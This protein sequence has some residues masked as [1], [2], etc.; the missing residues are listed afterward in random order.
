MA[1]AFLTKA[2][3]Q[4]SGP[5]EVVGVGLSS[6]SRG[7]EANTILAMKKI[8]IDLGEYKS[9]KLTQDVIN[10]AVVVLCM[11]KEHLNSLKKLFNSVP[12]RCYLWR[13]FLGNSDEDVVDPFGCDLETYITVR[14]SISEAIPS[15]VKFLREELNDY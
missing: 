10:E 8:G 3:E 15:I 9:K 11:T 6:A 5:F 13:G 14:N 12:S 7:A 2:L 4:E 1:E